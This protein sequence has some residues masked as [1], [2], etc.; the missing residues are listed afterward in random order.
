MAVPIR[1]AVAGLCAGLVAALLTT[2][3]ARA[4][5]HDRAWSV[6]S[7]AHAPRARVS[8]DSTTGA[9]SLSVSRAGR[10]VVE[11]SPVG[12]VTEQADL[13]QGLRFLH[14][15]DRVIDERYRTKAGKRL[16][17]RV[18]M[19]ESRLSFA[20]AAGARLDLVVRASSDGVAYRYVLPA[21]YGDV[22]GETSAFRLPADASAWLGTY[23]ADNE[24]Q[25]VRY[26]AASAPTGAYSDQALF[27]T[28]GGYTL[29][30]ESDLTGAYSGAR[31]S[32]EQGTGT[33]RIQLADDRVETEGP[34]ATPWRA[35]V[36]GDLATVTRSTFT[37]D[38]APASK[39]TDRSWIRPGTALWTWLAGGRPAGQS[40]AA[41][42]AYVD[43]AAERGWPYEA[44]D[45]G[46][47]FPSDAWDTTDPDWQ[48]NSWMPELV[49]Y[50]RAKGVGIIVWIHQRDLDT[51][52]E[53][54]Q[55]LPTLERWGVKGVKIDFMDSEAQSTLRWYDAILPETAA[56]HL[57]VNFHGSTIPKGIQRTWPH[58]M[59]LEGVAGEEKRTNTA[60]H[61]TTL[62]FTRNV[63][64]SMDFTPGAFQRVGLRPNSDAAEVGL[65]VAYESGLQMFAGTPESYDARPLARSY[66][67]Q[68]PGAWDD[69][70]LLAGQ[71]GQEAVLARRSGDRWFLGGVYAGAA[72]TAEV[73]L[74]LGSGRWLVETIRDG[75]DGLVQDRQVLRGG[76]TFTVDVTTN[77]GF[78]A[79]AC[80]WRPGV[81]TC[82]R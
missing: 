73:P 6:S 64:G 77:G 12:I 13:S 66:F 81:T 44:V 4:E 1:T 41:Q 29:L 35:M 11:P 75:A 38:L 16:D 57:L 70:R 3:P 63:I 76:D 67:D 45:A 62:P 23:R 50:A 47:Y 42:Q 72:R 46:W 52:E 31:L 54:A 59:T 21:A 71:P 27:A 33:Y 22:L 5:Q 17:R 43:Y 34:L 60:A 18:R 37:D 15:R 39:V 26:T 24:G 61:L 55:W 10:T 49:E 79:L 40:L 78:A 7:A 69:T 14:R 65:S 58:V 30:A 68:V 53:R 19:N 80:P 32:H 48:T 28:E 51:A 36:T 25:F 82:Y 8:L 20:T 56:H 2:A 74:S 9:L